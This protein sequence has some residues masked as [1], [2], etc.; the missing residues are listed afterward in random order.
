MQQCTAA[1]LGKEFRGEENQVF[2]VKRF[3]IPRI[4]VE[5]SETGPSTRA[6]YKF[7][8]I[9]LAASPRCFQLQDLS[10]D[11]HIQSLFDMLRYAAA[12]DSHWQ[13]LKMEPGLH[14]FF[15]E[16]RPSRVWWWR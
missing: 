1:L 9:A 14:E 5:Y 2:K 11:A 13:P 16:R 12:I 4:R 7:S 15:H 8:V 6:Y 3:F 10:I